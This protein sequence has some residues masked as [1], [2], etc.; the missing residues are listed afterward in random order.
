MN[1]YLEKFLIPVSL[2]FIVSVTGFIILN[3]INKI[4][5]ISENIYFFYSLFWIIILGGITGKFLIE[6][7]KNDI[8]FRKKKML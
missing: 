8:L 1:D 7:E 2:T 3:E 5:I 4:H 6:G